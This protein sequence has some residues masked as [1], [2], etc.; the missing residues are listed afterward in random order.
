MD[1]T[2]WVDDTGEFRTDSCT[3]KFYDEHLWCRKLKNN[4]YMCQL[5]PSFLFFTDGSAEVVAESLP[6]VLHE[7]P[8]ALFVPGSFDIAKW[9]RPFNYAFELADPTKPIT[10]KRG[11]PLYMVRF[12]CEDGD[13]VQLERKLMTEELDTA[14]KACLQVKAI[15]QKV[16]LK[17]LYGMASKYLELARARIFK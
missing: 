11:D 17:T 12:V 1:L 4:A 5:L 9:L 16:N 8:N 7:T 6:I 15:V 14:K 10:I 2:L 13:F 3:Q